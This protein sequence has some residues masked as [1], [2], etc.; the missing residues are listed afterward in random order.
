MTAAFVRGMAAG[1]LTAAVVVYYA[2]AI[3]LPEMEGR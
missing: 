3:V 2:V 1:A